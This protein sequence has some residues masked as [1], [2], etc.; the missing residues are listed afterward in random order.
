MTSFPDP[1]RD[2]GYKF[3][4]TNQQGITGSFGIT[5]GAAPIVFIDLPQGAQGFQLIAP[6]GTPLLNI[7][8]TGYVPPAP[9]VQTVTASGLIGLG[10]VNVVPPD[11]NDITLTL[12]PS[13]SSVGGQ[14]L[15]GVENTGFGTFVEAVPNGADKYI[16]NGSPTS[17]GYN[18]GNN[19]FFLWLCVRPGL[20]YASNNL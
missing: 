7:P 14:I 11:G 18:L 4:A 17:G 15:I 3:R 20:W 19:R 12:P 13:A 8:S 1:D 2:G 6:N 16:N 10:I 9:S 5:P